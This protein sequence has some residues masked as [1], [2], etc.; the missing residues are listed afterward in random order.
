MALGAKTTYNLIDMEALMIQKLP[1]VSL[2]TL[3]LF[4]STMVF[5]QAFGDYGRVVGGIPQGQGVAGPRAPDSVPRGGSEAGG[6]S[7]ARGKA[8]P[9]RLVVAAIAAGLYPKQDDESEQFAQLAQGEI[10]VPM[11]QSSG[12][13]GWY[14]VRTHQG[15]I[16][17]VKSADVRE[18]KVK[19]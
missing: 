16:G 8:V 7:D 5:A 11:G 9:S 6:V 2:T 17:W 19:K 10:L 4:S 3:L 12:G 13:N 1:A 15:M 18:E 14:M